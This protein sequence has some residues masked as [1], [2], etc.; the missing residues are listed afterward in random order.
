MSV[1][2]L[3]NDFR[4]DYGQYQ[5][6]AKRQSGNINDYIK[7]FTRF[8]KE[9]EERLN[10]EIGGREVTST[11]T[12]PVEMDEAMNDLVYW[13]QLNT[14]ETVHNALFVMINSYLEWSL[15]E[16]C[17][18]SGIYIG[19]N[20]YKYNNEQGIHKAKN[21]LKEKLKI[22]INTGG[23]EWSRFNVNQVI[24][25]LIVHNGANAIKDYDKGLED[26]PDYKTKLTHHKHFYITETGFL[27]IREMNYIQ[28]S[29]NWA[30]DFVQQALDAV[31]TELLNNRGVVWG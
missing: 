27:Y 15:V 14:K 5:T 30:M 21:Y 18:L 7:H 29:H 13:A 4:F 6:Q 23:K 3:R 8:L 12:I 9:K 24:R 11:T 2:Y 19:D 16:L 17:R 26:Q 1:I 25:N 28:E 20:F 31:R 22:P 10:A